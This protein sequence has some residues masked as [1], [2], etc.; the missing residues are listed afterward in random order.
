[1]TLTVDAI[2][3]LVDAARTDSG[4]AV[5]LQRDGAEAAEVLA[6]EVRSL[7]AQRDAWRTA[8]EDTLA[9]LVAINDRLGQALTRVGIPDP[10]RMPTDR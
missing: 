8:A 3:A 9:K 7:R 2:L 1:M 4:A 6:A 5:R 10:V